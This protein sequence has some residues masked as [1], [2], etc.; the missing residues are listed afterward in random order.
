MQ[1][2]TTSFDKAVDR[3]AFDCGKHPDLNTY[4]ASYAGQDERRNVSRTFMLVNSGV[5]QG[6]YTLAATAIDMADLSEEQRK[7]LPRYPLPAVLLSRLAVS[8]DCQRQGLGQR[9][10]KDIFL[11]VCAMAELAGVAFLV[12]DAKDEEAANYY[13]SLGFVASPTDKLRLAILTK[14]CIEAARS[15]VEKPGA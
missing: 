9:L 14:T 15:S 12:V 3:A 7:G 11:R 4:I 8:K 5:L 1:F 2:I 10:L 13:A 6:F